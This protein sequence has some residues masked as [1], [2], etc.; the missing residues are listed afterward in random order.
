[1]DEANLRVLIEQ[2]QNGEVSADD[3][4]IQIARLPFAEVGQAKVDH[5]RAIRQGLPEAVYAPGK[6]PQQCVEIVGEL[7]TNGSGPVVI[8]RVDEDQRKAIEA[9]H[10]HAA[11][12][13]NVMSWRQAQPSE[14][15]TVAVITAGTA[16][17]PVADECQATL[18]A[19]GV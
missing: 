9:V 11:T 8:T 5:H 4:L 10:P 17:T 12:L 7:L 2:L 18:E 1:M 15:F 6:S 14:D 13:G 16:D 3:A 19:Y